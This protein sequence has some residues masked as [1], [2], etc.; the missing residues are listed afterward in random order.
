MTATND[1]SQRHG[2]K[3]LGNANQTETSKPVDLATYSQT[4]AGRMHMRGIPCIAP[5][6]GGTMPGTDPL[7]A[8]LDAEDDGR[9]SC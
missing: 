1:L 2:D 3:M 7:Q 9:E 4:A 5:R 6:V 8:L